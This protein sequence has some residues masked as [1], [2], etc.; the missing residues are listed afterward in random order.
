M[1]EPGSWEGLLP[2]RMSAGLHPVLLSMDEALLTTRDLDP[3]AMSYPGDHD[4]DEVLMRPL[5]R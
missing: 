1:A 4:A 2:A 5:G 3:G